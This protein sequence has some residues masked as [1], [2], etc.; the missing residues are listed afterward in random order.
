MEK[1]KAF[2]SEARLVLLAGWLA[3][4]V[5]EVITCFVYFAGR[6]HDMSN[7]RKLYLSSAKMAAVLK[8]K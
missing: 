7:K 4:W 8:D 5:E 3:S 2:W 6:I 1:R